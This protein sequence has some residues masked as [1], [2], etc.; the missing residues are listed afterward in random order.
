[1]LRTITLVTRMY[2]STSGACCAAE[3]VRI[4]ISRVP[5]RQ[6]LPGQCLLVVRVHEGAVAALRAQI[7]IAE[8]RPLCSALKPRASRGLGLNFGGPP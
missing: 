8:R 3:V 5:G 2:W 4:D 1:M 7:G 6:S